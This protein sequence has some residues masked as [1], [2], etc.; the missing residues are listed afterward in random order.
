MASLPPPDW[1]R[2]LKGRVLLQS[3]IEE[4]LE[5]VCVRMNR[6]NLGHAPWT[7]WKWAVRQVKNLLVAFENLAPGLCCGGVHKAAL[8]LYLGCNWDWEDT[9]NLALEVLRLLLEGCTT[10]PE[11]LDPFELDSLVDIAQALGDTVSDVLEAGMAERFG[12]AID[13]SLEALF[14][15]TRYFGNPKAEAAKRRL[16]EPEVDLPSKLIALAQQP[17]AAWGHDGRQDREGVLERDEPLERYLSSCN[18]IVRVLSCLVQKKSAHDV[19]ATMM[20]HGVLMKRPGVFVAFRELLQVGADVLYT[21]RYRELV[22][23]G[24]QAKASGAGMIRNMFAMVSHGAY[25]AGCAAVAEWKQAGWEP[26]L[27]RIQ[28]DRTYQGPYRT[29]FQ[30]MSTFLLEALP[31]FRGAD[32]DALGG[33]AFRFGEK[34]VE[35]TLQMSRPAGSPAT[36]RMDRP[37]DPS[38]LVENEL[39]RPTGQTIGPDGQP[40]N[41]YEAQTMVRTYH[42]RCGQCGKDEAQLAEEA[43]AAAA[44]GA[45]CS[46]AAAG[47]QGQEAAGG[48]RLRA[49]SSCRRAHYCSRECQVAH[50]PEHK[51]QCKRYR[52]GLE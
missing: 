42:K 19:A 33:E 50:W 10:T 4:T 46:S 30:Q 40:L 24:P 48:V 11:G 39:R 31:A 5:A 36:L 47:D 1:R 22:G 20:Q 32:G 23:D 34:L 45:A 29:Y 2:L 51:A 13:H 41:T 15:V 8:Q 35:I 14:S 18:K 28:S 6:C 9:N 3:R 21:A 16:W 25:S 49:C 7:N 43:A 27:R 12:A 44:A 37:R 17:L 26:V 52:K 38:S